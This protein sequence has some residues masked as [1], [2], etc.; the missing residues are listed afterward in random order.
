M[1]LSTNPRG[2]LAWLWADKSVIALKLTFAPGR[3]EPASSVYPLKAPEFFDST[4][5]PS[6]ELSCQTEE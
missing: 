2:L 3:F 4:Y 5:D 6:L 1:L